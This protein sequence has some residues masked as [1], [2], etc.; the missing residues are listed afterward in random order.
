MKKRDGKYHLK[1]VEA[2]SKDYFSREH[3]AQFM[4]LCPLCAP[5]YR[6]FVKLDESAMKDLNHALKNSEEPEVSLNS[7]EIETSIRFV[8]SHF[9]DIKTILGEEK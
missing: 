2:L 4:A 7:G 1:A 8:E 5:M 6:E 9:S 3:E